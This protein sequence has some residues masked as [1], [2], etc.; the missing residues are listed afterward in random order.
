MVSHPEQVPRVLP[1]SIRSAISLRGVSI[2][3]LPGDLALQDAMSSRPFIPFEQPKATVCPSKEEVAKLAEVLN[4][5]QKVTILG[6]AG[7]AGAHLELV[8]VAEIGR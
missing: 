1:I 8:Q 4:S 6:G 3:V 5:A 7:C 2:I